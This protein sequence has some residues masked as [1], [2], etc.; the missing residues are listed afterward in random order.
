MDSDLISFNSYEIDSSKTYSEINSNKIET[1][2]LNINIL[3]G[4]VQI[5]YLQMSGTGTINLNKGDIIVQMS[6][7]I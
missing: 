1:S 4:R 5:H 3:E 7:P 2:D 6:D